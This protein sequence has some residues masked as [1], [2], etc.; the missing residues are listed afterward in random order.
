[1]TERILTR[2]IMLT[3]LSAFLLGA[4][5]LENLGI[6]YVSEGGNPLIKIHLYSY[7]SM[8]AFALL[9]LRVG[10]WGLIKP[11]QTIKQAWLFAMLSIFAVIVYGLMRFG[12]SG[13]AYLVDTILVPLLLVPIIIRLSQEGKERLLAFI[14]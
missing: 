9:I 12:T 10:F 5:L 7:L 13:L 11:L 8:G 4:Y 6:Q 3:I 1:M 14:G 2:W